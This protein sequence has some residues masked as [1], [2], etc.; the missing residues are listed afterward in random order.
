MGVTRVAPQPGEADLLADVVITDLDGEALVELHRVQF[1]PITPARPVLEELDRLWMEGAFDPR[2]RRHPAGRAQGLAGERAFLVAAGDESTNWARDYATERGTE[3]LLTVRGG[4]L[5]QIAPRWR[6]NC[7]RRLGGGDDVR[8]VVVTLIA[9][10]DADED[11][12]LSMRRAGELP[13]MLA[14]VARAAQNVQDEAALDGR[15]LTMHGLVI[16]RGAIPVPGPVPAD[17]PPDLAASALVGARRV[18]RNEQMLMNWRL[19]DIDHASR[20]PTVVLE[21]LVTEAYA[22]DDADEVALRQDARMVLVYQSSLSGHLEAL[23]E[24][25][26]LQDL[27]TNFEMEAPPG[28]LADLVLREISRRDPGP[29]E[30]EIRMDGIG[31][32]FKD[33][34]KI[35]GVLGE[36]EL[37]GTWFGLELGMEGMGVVTRVGPG[38]S[39][40]TVGESRFVSVPGMARRYIT[41]KWDEGAFEPGD[42]LTLETCGSVVVFMTAHYALKHAARVQ[43]NEWVLVTGGA[44][45]VGMAAVQ[46]AAKAGAQ[47]IATASTPERGDMLRSLGAKHVVDSRSLSAVEEVRELTGG[48]GADV[49]LNSAPGEAVVATLEAAAE[50]GR[51]VEVGKTEIFGGRL[52]DMGVFNK[53]LSL[54][55]VDMDRMMAY[56]KDLAQQ[57]S[58]E[59]LALLRAGEYELLPTRVMPVSQLA[60]AFA[61]VARSNHLGR[62]VLDFNEPAPPVKRARPVTD[63]RPDAALP[64]HRWSRRLRPGHR[65]VAGRQGRGPDRA[66]R[67]AGR[68]QPRAS[69][70]RWRRCGPVAPTCGSSRW[71]W[72]T[73]PAW[74]HCSPGCPTGRPCVGCSTPP[75]SSRTSCSAS[76]RETAWTRCSRPRSRARSFSTR[77]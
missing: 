3:Q 28:R 54:I 57:V 34:M 49:V 35:L 69:R 45:G 15:D 75:A 37:A 19:V 32:N 27:D 17:E 74:T 51:V 39:G 1:R 61:Q 59:V 25:G 8:P 72:P 65:E 41:T 9:V 16:T 22:G 23:E 7:A 44:G 62:I 42:G 21:S 67:P 18:L 76:S 33:P 31:L 36:A 50:F 52:I 12:A 68:G 26:P 64:G 58:R 13:A 5:D 10:T 77:P 24:M 60:D 6:P 2:P 40:F 47:V 30:I 56:R 55:S 70:P 71:T 73:G 11:S 43:P 66:G 38:V 46:V 14:G 4:G 53:N 63:I 29:G 48:H 20:L